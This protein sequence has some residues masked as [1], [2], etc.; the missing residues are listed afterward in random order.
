MH[1]LMNVRMYV[2]GC[3]CVCVSILVRGQPCKGKVKTTKEEFSHITVLKHWNSVQLII[4]MTARK[5]VLNNLNYYLDKNST[6]Q[7]NWTEI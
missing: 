5:K 2:S 6:T 3:M 7:K 4:F 1:E